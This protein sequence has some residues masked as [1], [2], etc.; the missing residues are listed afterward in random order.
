MFAAGSEPRRELAPAQST[1]RQRSRRSGAR[2]CARTGAGEGRR[3]SGR[4]EEGRG[5]VQAPGGVCGVASDTATHPHGVD[6]RQRSPLGIF[7]EASHLAEQC[8][9]AELD[10]RDLLKDGGAV[11]LEL[12]HDARAPRVVPR[13]RVRDRVFVVVGLR[14]RGRER[15]GGRERGGARAAAPAASRQCRVRQLGEIRGRRG[16]GHDARL[17]V[18]RGAG[19]WQRDGWARVGWRWVG[20]RWVGW[21]GR[22]G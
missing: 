8:E 6:G 18:L 4:A 2:R 10:D 20:W 11:R 9:D 14:G 19:A 13:A 16:G 21:R 7:S 22:A 15:E 1:A 12:G 17:R 5:L 3:A